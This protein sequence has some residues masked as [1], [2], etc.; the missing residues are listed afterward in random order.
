M[1]YIKRM[2]VYRSAVDDGT[3]KSSVMTIIDFSNT[4]VRTTLDQIGTTIRC[5]INFTS[6]TEGSDSN[7]DGWLD[8]VVTHR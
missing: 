3:A 8:S 2:T 7:H 1:G 6:V 5:C 4:V